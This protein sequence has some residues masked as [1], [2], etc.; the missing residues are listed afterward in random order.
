M[1]EQVGPTD[2][3]C[4]VVGETGTGKELVAR[5]LHTLSPRA[6]KPFVVVDCGGL[7]GSLVTSSLF[8]HA[9]R[10]FTGAV[11]DSVG[12]IESAAG[13][14]L[15]LD[16]LASLPLELQPILLRVLESGTFQR[17]GEGRV[18][19]VDFRLIASTTR[20]LEGEVAAGR[21]RAD[22]YYRVATQGLMRGL[23]LRFPLC[24]S[25]A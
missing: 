4:L 3:S 15:Y 22:L 16:E 11:K 13:G 17:V 20:E 7:V 19:E 8:G 9:R 25:Y 5:T 21:F 14:T 23:A 1:V 18:R 12:L 10:A 6:A 2:A 24:F